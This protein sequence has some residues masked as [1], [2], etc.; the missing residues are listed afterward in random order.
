MEN[1]D[2]TGLSGLINFDIYGR[3]TDFQMNVLEL[4]RT[5]LE[6]IGMIWTCKNQIW[7]NSKKDNFSFI[8]DFHHYLGTWSAKEKLNLS[9]QMEIVELDSTLN[10]MSNK[11]FVVTMIESAPYVMLKQEVTLRLI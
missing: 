10:V 6:K 5:G 1:Q 2:V 4:R 8:I 11:T 3:R 7:S 9:R